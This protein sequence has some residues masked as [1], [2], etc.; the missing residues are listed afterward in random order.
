MEICPGIIMIAITKAKINFLPLKLYF[1][2]AKPI[3][4]DTSTLRITDTTDTVMELKYALKYP[5]EITSFRLA[6]K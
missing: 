1:A 4:V 3:M 2:S 5:L 6:R